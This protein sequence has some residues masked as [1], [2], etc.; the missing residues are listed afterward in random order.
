[1]ITELA[2]RGYGYG[3]GLISADGKRF[4]VNIPKNASSY[5]LN[6]TG[7]HG[8]SAAVVSDLPAVNQIQEMIVVLR[9]PVERWIS[10]IAQYINTYILSVEGPNGPIYKVQDMTQYDR[11]M[12]AEEW[13]KNYNQNSE[14]LLFDIITRFDDHVWPQHELFENL[15]PSVPRKFF[16]LDNSF[17]HNISQYLGL[18]P[19]ADLDRNQGSV[20]TNIAKLQEFFQNRLAVRPELRQRIKDAYFQD[21]K[22]IR[23]IFNESR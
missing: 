16:Y 4:I 19:V 23:E 5:L 18:D 7:C 3:S 17:D 21:Y 20:Q 15:L 9:D 13:I 1:M 22:L 11:P 14:R 8:Y 2:R 10:G 6:W 12:S